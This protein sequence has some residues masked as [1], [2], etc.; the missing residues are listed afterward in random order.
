MARATS[1][2]DCEAILIDIGGTLRRGQNPID[3]A[4][5]FIKILRRKNVPHYCLTNTTTVSRETLADELHSLRFKI[6]AEQLLTANMSAIAYL[7]RNN[8][9]S[10]YIVGTENQ[11]QEFEEHGIAVT[12]TNAQAVIASLD[13]D[14]SY[15]T[16]ATASRLIRQGAVYL[17]T[18]DDPNLVSHDGLRP[19]AGATV[20]FLNETTEQEPIITGKPYSQIMELALEQIGA[21]AASM[22]IIGDQLGID[23]K[24]AEEY[25]MVSVLVLSGQTE[26]DHLTDAAYQP[27]YIVESVENLIPLFK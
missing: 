19:D 23:M 5:D 1:L 25:G 14:L 16:L 9:T 20:A 6:S 22:A 21:P 2:Q 26:R 3:G 18:N 27:D 4:T 10:A 12:D 8:I 11:K 7:Q 17:A 13:Y 24:L 15:E